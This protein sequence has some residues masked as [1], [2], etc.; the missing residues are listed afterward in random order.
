[1]GMRQKEVGLG[2]PG[3]CFARGIETVCL[4]KSCI[5]V[6][7]YNNNNIIIIYIYLGRQFGSM[8]MYAT[9][10]IETI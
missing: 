3:S 8:Y 7:V 6:H 2:Q 10:H 1:M 9:K 5:H 4:H